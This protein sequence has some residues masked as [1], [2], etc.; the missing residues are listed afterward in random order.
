M[1]TASSAFRVG[2][3]GDQGFISPV[4]PAALTCEHARMEERSQLVRLALRL[5]YSTIVWNV[6]EAGLTIGLG[7]AAGSLAL[8]GFGTDSII[9]VFAS[10]VVVWHLRPGHET[11]YPLRTARALR[12]VGSAFAVLAVA[13]SIAGLRDLVTGRRP[14]ESIWGAVYLV[15]VAVVMFGLGTTKHR[16]AGRLD[17]APLRA[18]ATMTMLDAALA[19]GTAIGLGLNI[20]VDWWRA[21]PIAALAV[22]VIAANEARKNFEEAREWVDG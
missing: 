22:A 3:R 11:D 4:W 5:E 1:G 7:L 10:L 14:D 13:L 20:V 21:D 18:E 15:G 2:G 8:I 12:L 17:S 9:E 6:G 16:I 19:A